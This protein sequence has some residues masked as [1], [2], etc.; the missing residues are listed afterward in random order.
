MTDVFS[1]KQR[2]EIMA[3]VKGKDTKPERLVRSMLHRNGFR[4]R[5]HRNDLP[6]KPDIVL[7]GKGVVI[8][9]HGCFW[10]QHKGCKAAQRPASNS[11]Y[12]VAKLDNNRRRDARNR[13]ALNKLGWKVVVVWE[14]S[15]KYPNRAES[16]LKQILENM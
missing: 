2:S 14:C 9:V 3:R 11:A 10:H 8:F 15:L 1:Q 13:R 12:W 7:P 5:L 4:F 16:R 6:G